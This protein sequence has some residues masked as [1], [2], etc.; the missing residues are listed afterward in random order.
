M[1]VFAHIVSAFGY[2]TALGALIVLISTTGMNLI[3]PAIL[4]GKRVT[5]LELFENPGTFIVPICVAASGM[6]VVLFGILGTSGEREVEARVESL[7]PEN[8]PFDSAPLRGLAQ[9]RP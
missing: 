1:R 5:P 6:I 4:S 7:P 9:T 2:L 8:V 3:L